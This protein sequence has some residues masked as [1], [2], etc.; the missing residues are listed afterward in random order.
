[1]STATSPGFGQAAALRKMQQQGLGSM[2]MADLQASAGLI[3]RRS[4]GQRRVQDP[5][6][7]KAKHKKAA[8]ARKKN[9][10]R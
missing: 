4:K 10:R 9:R 3:G 7:A 2:S 5:N 8:K 1:M 6:K